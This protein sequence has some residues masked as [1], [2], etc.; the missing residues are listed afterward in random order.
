MVAL[1]PPEPAP[2]SNSERTPIF[3]PA[4][5]EGTWRRIGASRFALPRGAGVAIAVGTLLLV[6]IMLL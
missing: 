3:I 2:R 1:R 4:Q 5:P 6:I